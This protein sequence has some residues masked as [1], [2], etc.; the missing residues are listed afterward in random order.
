MKALKKLISCLAVMTFIYA[1]K[2]DSVATDST[3]NIGRGGSMARFTIAKDYLY[4][5][6]NQ[7]LKVFRITEPENPISVKRVPLNTVVETIFPFEGHLL[8][9]TQTGMFIFSISDP[10]NPSRISTYSHVVS[11]DPV[12]AD[13]NY[14]YVTLR[15]GTNCNRGINALDVVDIRDMTNPQLL[16]SYP[17]QNPHGLGVDGNLLFVTEGNHGLKVFDKTNPNDLK[18]IKTFQDFTAFDV[19]PESD[20]LIITGKQGI[21]QYSYNAQNELKLLSKIPIES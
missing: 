13:G 6:D 8:V 3:S 15:S 11:C 10:E 20:V 12:V 4:I 19:I 18:L 17:M 5:V 7:S 9:G 16:K 21:Y 1:C 14:A 2:G